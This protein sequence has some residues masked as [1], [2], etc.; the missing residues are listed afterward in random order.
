MEAFYG[1][2]GADEQ[3][4]TVDTTGHV[5]RVD[6]FTLETDSAGTVDFTAFKNLEDAERFVAAVAEG[7]AIAGDLG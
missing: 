4:G 5:F 6:R 7:E 2:G 3:A 1:A